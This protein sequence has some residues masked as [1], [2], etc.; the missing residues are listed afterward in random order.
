VPVEVVAV[1]SYGE[2]KKSLLGNGALIFLK[3]SAPQ[4]LR[5]N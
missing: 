3:T 2:S 5:Y 4:N 1:N